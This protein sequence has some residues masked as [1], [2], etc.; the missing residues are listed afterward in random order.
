[1]P[2]Q[3]PARS[4]ASR[5]NGRPSP[6]RR[7]APIRSPARA[8]PNTRTSRRTHREIG[9]ARQEL[10]RKGRRAPTRTPPLSRR[11]TCSPDE[12][13]KRPG[14]A[15]K[16]IVP[17]R[18]CRRPRRWPAARK[19]ATAGRWPCLGRGS[20]SPPQTAAMARS[21]IFSATNPR[22]DCHDMRA[23]GQQSSSRS[24]SGS[25][26][27][28]GLAIRPKA[29]STSTSADNE[30]RE[31]VPG[32]A[33][34]GAEGEHEEQSAQ[35]VLPFRHPSHRFDAQWMDGEYGRHEGGRPAVAGHS[36]Q[37]QEKHRGDGRVQ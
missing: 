35:D 20:S 30:A 6:G 2:R 8:F 25:D 22:H 33:P 12:D 18:S 19:A 23:S 26:T 13:R 9:A 7:P 29:N 21:G 11:A 37:D 17:G 36:P 3:C 16:R 32:I 24:T 15:D 5:C 34:I 28:I 1:M 4:R 31:G 10:P 27:N 14:P